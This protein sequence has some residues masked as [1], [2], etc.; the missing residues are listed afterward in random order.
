MRLRQIVLAALYW[1]LLPG[2]LFA[3]ERTLKGQG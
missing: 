1:L 2:I 3:Q